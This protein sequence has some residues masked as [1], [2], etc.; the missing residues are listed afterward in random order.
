MTR[1]VSRP[2]D[3]LRVVLLVHLKTGRDGPSTLSCTRAD[4]TSTWGKL[5][6]FFPVHD[7][8]HYAVESLLGLSHAFFGLIAAGWELDDFAGPGAAAR[9]PAEALW[10]EH[11]VG[12]LDR[13]RASGRLLS[14]VEVRE[15]LSAA[16]A[17]RAPQPSID[18]AT[19]DAIRSLRDRLEQRW[20]ALAPGDTLRLELPAPA[21]SAAQAQRATPGGA[22]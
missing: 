5:H 14:A 1:I 17:G 4:G 19:L 22:P 16:L 2:P 20:H 21:E 15:T 9:L 6:P 18:E 3:R 12:L 7:L 11:L 8:T 13:E 10:A